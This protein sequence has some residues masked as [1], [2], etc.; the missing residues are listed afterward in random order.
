MLLGIPW[1]INVV[2]GLVGAFPDLY[3]LPETMRGIWNNLYKKSHAIF[4][5]IPLPDGS[6]VDGAPI[7]WKFM[8]PPML[9]HIF[10]DRLTHKSTGGW[11]WWAY[12]IEAILDIGVVLFI[13]LNW[14]VVYVGAIVFFGIIIIYT[15][16]VLVIVGRKP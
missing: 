8:I 10:F 7:V 5:I 4:D 1:W 9:E 14:H 16:L 6:T 3:A 13:V 2:V 12:V 11:Y 15:L